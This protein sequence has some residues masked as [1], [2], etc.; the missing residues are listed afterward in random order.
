MRIALLAAL[1]A[2]PGLWAQPAGT[3][4]LG[5]A[6]LAGMTFSGGWG[7]GAETVAASGPGFTQALRL[8][9][10]TLPAA[11]RPE[12]E[13]SLRVRTPGVLAVKKGDTVLASV[14]A[15]CV[16]PAAGD[17]AARFVVEGALE[18]YTR[19]TSTM[20]IA[21]AEWKRFSVPFQM[22]QDYQP[23]QYSVQ[24]WMGAQLQVVELAA[25]TVSHHGTASF[26]QLGVDTRYEGAAPDAPWRKAAAERIEKLRKG[27]LEIEVVDA[28]GQPVKGAQVRARMK[29]H[30]FGFGTAVAA[31]QLL[32][33]TPD[34]ERY[35]KMV[36]ELFNMVV[37]E[38]DLKWPQWEADRQ[39][40][41]DGLA[42]LR[43]NNMNRV[44]G[45][46]LVWPSWRW[47]PPDLK[48]LAG[49]PAA[50]RK[51]VFDHLE[52]EVTATRGMI[53]HWD[54]VNEP[55]T[56]RDMLDILGDEEMAAWFHATR[57]AD[58]KPVLFI[59]DFSILSARGADILH[60]NHYYNTIG[61]LLKKGAPV[62]GIG[63]QGHFSDPTPPERMLRIL[64]RFAKFGKPIAIT[65][66]DFNIT[67]EALQAGFT[68]DFLTVV[69]SH[70]QVDSFLMWGFWEGRHWRPN[71]AMVRRNWATK[72]NY[73]AYRDLVF[74]QWWTDAAGESGANGVWKT[75][76][77]LG[78]YEVEVKWGE[79]VATQVAEI[80]KSGSR[81]KIT[82]PK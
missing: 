81:V 39:R 67:D 70:P 82:L 32:G 13:W 75:R 27:D 58:P 63:M 50:M 3:S 20:L 68:R 66:F 46:T 61:M 48:K 40:A 60:Q 2:T 4:M 80:L 16:E 36:L 78:N 49:D 25:L 51:R 47:L 72:P 45:H 17:C 71:G 18:P 41:L 1:A 8:A 73:D 29:R 42:W 7:G 43:A 64:D 31:A 33:T 9:T 6:G 56:N 30:A 5:P 11:I 38:N 65:E 19:S 10:R 23:G 34:A 15:R 44:R 59:N 54:V 62:E 37:F 12:V 14:Y 53:D 77:F 22:A 21:G 69:F 76:G 52:D 26:A 24:F 55:Y 79:V 74:K 28:K 57:K 35:R